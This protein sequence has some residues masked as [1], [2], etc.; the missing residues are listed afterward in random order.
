MTPNASAGV[1]SARELGITTTDGRTL[2]VYEAGDQQGALVIVHHGTPCSGLL[3]TPW[4]AD[5]ERR[6][7]RLVAFDR[8][9]YGGSTRR[10]GRSVADVAADTAAV[11][12]ALG[13]ERF[14]TWGVSGGGPHALACAALLSDRVLSAACL[15]GVAPYDA[16]S[17][18][19]MAGM[20]QDNV[21]E[22]EAALGGEEALSEYLGAA[23]AE[24]LAA[25]PEQLLGVMRSLLPPA[26]VAVLTGERAAFL[27]A[28]MT[29]GLEP[30]YEG[31]L[32]DDLALTTAWGFTPDASRVPVLLMQGEQDLMVPFGHGRWLAAALP[33]AEAVL[34]ADH[35]H[36]TLLEDI[37]RVHAWLLARPG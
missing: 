23:R 25:T 22:F 20:G 33:Q 35:G 2:L 31:W 8:P 21:E 10:S 11:A 3:A 34:S 5:A 12:D 4:A 6:G 9:G 27:H 19:W 13:A 15:A 16:P 28:W 24:L 17:L 18:D 36:L 7:I 29:H 30:G 14:R 32:D 26:D 1:A 37:S